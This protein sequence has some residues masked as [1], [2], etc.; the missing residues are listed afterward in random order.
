MAQIDIVRSDGTA[1]AF[2]VRL[3]ETPEEHRRGLMHVRHL[4]A[5]EGMLFVFDPPRKVAFWM[6]N[7][8]VPLDMIFIRPD[9]IIGSI[10]T[11]RDTG[12]DA[13]TASG[14]AVG[15]VLE[16]RAGRAAALGIE[17]GDRLRR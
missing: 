1:A 16:I 11:R 17:A 4:D 13:A 12:S 15:A 2:R 3:A 8:H 10:K 7:T 5:D 9:G 14:F 6:R